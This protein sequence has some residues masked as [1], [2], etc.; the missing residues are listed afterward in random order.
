MENLQLEFELQDKN[1]LEIKIE[2]LQMQLIA[3][4]KSNE[5][6]RKKLFAEMKSVI[7]FCKTLQDE[8]TKL[9]NEL[10]KVQNEKAQWIYMQRDCL[11]DVQHVEKCGSWFR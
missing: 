10:R 4:K 5:S 6:V 9:F 7:D 3:Q 2:N 1:S 11:F 8:N